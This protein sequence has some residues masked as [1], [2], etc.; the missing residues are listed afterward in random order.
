MIVA[1]DCETTGVDWA[2]GALPFLVTACDDRGRQTWWCWDVDPLTRR[3]DVPRE[4]LVEI[5]DYMDAAERVVWQNGKFDLKM[6]T[7]LY[8]AYGLELRWDWGKT[9]DTLSATHLL[10]T[11][12][13]HDLT[14]SALLYLGVDISGY[15]QVM[16]EIVSKDRRA[17]QQ[18]RL[19]ARRRAAKESE[20]PDLYGGVAVAEDPLAEWMIAEEGLPCMPSAKSGSKKD[21]KGVE[22]DSPW[23]FD[24]W[25]PRAVARLRDTQEP[26]P[27][28]R[29]EWGDDHVCA[30]C[31]GDHRWTVTAEYANAD[32]ATTLALWLG[33]GNIPGLRELLE[34]RKLTAI[35]RES[36]RVNKAT[37]RMESRGLNF[38]A[39][40]ADALEPEYRAE[41][42]AAEADC[43]GLAAGMGYDLKLPRGGNNKSL[44][45]FLF[46]GRHEENPESNGERWLDLP[47]VEWTEGGAPSLNKNAMIKYAAILERDSVQARF[48]ARLSKKRKRDTSLTYIAGYR[49]FAVQDERGLHRLYPSVNPTGT[50]TLRFSSSNP[51]GQNISKQSGQCERCEGRGCEDC[52]YAGKTRS[53]RC[54]FGPEPGREW[55]SFDYENI[56]LRIPAYKS[57][58]QELIDLFERSAEPPYFGSQ[59]IL[60]FSVVY[61][62]LWAEALAKAGPEKAAKWI[63][64]TW[65]ATWYQWCKNGDF[66]LQYN[67]GRETADRAF[68]RAGSYDRLKSKFSLLEA[69]NQACIREANKFGYVETLPDASVDPERGYPIV[70]SRA[71]YGRI[72]PTIPLSYKTQSTAMQCTRRA[73]VRCD[74]YLEELNRLDPRGYY[75]VLQVHDECVFDFPAGGRKNL[76]KVRRIK[77][78]MEQSGADIG[79]PLKVSAKYHP[80]NWGEA[81]KLETV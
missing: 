55:W 25:L 49:R 31:D 71:E 16:K 12:V 79:V 80:R 33:R 76:P 21:K 36:L 59:H 3:P 38:L 32:S 60:N 10:N 70:C 63:K 19:K 27:G 67:C 13:Q 52:D 58:Q 30:L 34:R 72:S 65:D 15:E 2:H 77:R 73:M 51:N 54:C 28:C 66:A 57:G 68:H 47:P 8:R 74:E 81:V 18:A 4:D 45:T 69:Y 17:V 35:Y 64:E 9:E 41:S 40:N 42:S 62:D 11:A 39:A 56:E 6:L 44:T 22:S 26:V 50:G 75:L 7:C 5:Q 37:A 23:K 43:V 78:L 24:C 14:A 53:V 20:E 48:L 1:M 46:G 61:E 29:H